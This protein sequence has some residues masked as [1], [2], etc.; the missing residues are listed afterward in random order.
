MRGAPR[1]GG[2]TEVLPSLRGAR[3]RASRTPSRP[4]LPQVSA[5]VRRGAGGAASTL[6]VGARVSKARRTLGSRPAGAATAPPRVPSA[7][8]PAGWAPGALGRARGGARRPARPGTF[9][10][11]VAGPARGAQSW[12]P[13]TRPARPVGGGKSLAE[14]TLGAGGGAVLSSRSFNE[15]E[16][17][18]GPG[19]AP[20][21]RP[22]LAARGPFKKVGR[23]TSSKF[24]NWSRRRSRGKRG[25]A[26]RA[27]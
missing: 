5:G 26:A 24:K 3:G 16:P 11:G 7:S 14:A 1:A 23:A 6:P 15:A 8:V 2:H 22:P 12:G 13:Q 25:V 18:R 9:Q 19:V 17:G 10:H 21:L 20:S 27:G 4:R